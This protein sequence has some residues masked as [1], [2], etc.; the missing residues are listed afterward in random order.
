MMRDRLPLPE[1]PAGT[2][3]CMSIAV[4]LDQLD[5]RLA[6]FPWGYLMTVRDDGRAQ[7]LAVP[8]RLVD[9]VLVATIGRSAAGNAAARPNVTMIFPGSSGEELSLIVDGEARVIGD[10]IEVTPTWAVMHRPALGSL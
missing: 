8:T 4:T 10:R 6:Q 3:Q 1:D 7:G 9:G 2:L 5:E